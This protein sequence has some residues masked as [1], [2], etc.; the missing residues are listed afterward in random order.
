MKNQKTKSAH[1]IEIK[2]S[3]LHQKL[4]ILKATKKC[5]SLE[6][7]I[8]YL[9]DFFNEEG[10]GKRQTQIIE[11]IADLEEIKQISHPEFTQEKIVKWRK[12][13]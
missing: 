2:D 4:L 5:K 3:L 10:D 12:F 9:Y 1:R 6:K 13:L 11:Y 7:V 8:Q